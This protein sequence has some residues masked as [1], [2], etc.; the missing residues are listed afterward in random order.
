MLRLG[1]GQR[2]RAH[3]APMEGAEEGDHL[4]PFGVIAGQLQRAL[5]GLGPGVAKEKAVRAGHGRDGRKPLGQIGQMLVVKVRAGDV[6][7]LSGLFL[8]GGH[9]LRVAMA[10][11]NRSDARRKVKELIAVLVFHADAAATLGHQRI[12]ACVAG[13]NQPFVGG[14]H[15]PGLGPRQ[16][17]DELGSVLRVHFLLG[18]LLFS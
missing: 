11:R 13:R 7:Q 12:R 10:G 16:R 9:D 2:E 8:N 4:L 1:A 6:Q 17:T 18:H 3:G 5:D 14:N 15:R